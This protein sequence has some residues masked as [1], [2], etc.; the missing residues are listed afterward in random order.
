M[1]GLVPDRSG[2]GPIDLAVLQ[3]TDTRGA[4]P[5]DEYVTCAQVLPRIDERTG[6]GPRYAYDVL[7]DLARPWVIAVPTIAA[8]GNIG[9]REF[10][11]CR[12]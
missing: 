1:A 6:L 8:Q 7:L 4:N 2:C 10:R 5:P 12:T 9:D 3:A 11:S